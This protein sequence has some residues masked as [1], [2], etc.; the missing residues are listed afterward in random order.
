MEERHEKKEE[1]EDKLKGMK[2][3]TLVRAGDTATTILVSTIGK[4]C[5]S[6]RYRTKAV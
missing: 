3:K 4:S 6:L 1:R 2:I 5:R